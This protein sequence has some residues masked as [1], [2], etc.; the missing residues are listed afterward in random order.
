MTWK[1]D[2]MVRMDPV[3]GTSIRET[4]SKRVHINEWCLGCTKDRKDL[5]VC[6]VAGWRVGAK[7]P[8]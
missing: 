5:G 7:S 3:V 8:R 2:S 4:S 6:M 1:E